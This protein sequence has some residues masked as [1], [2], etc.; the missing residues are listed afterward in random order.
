MGDETGRRH[1]KR[2][3]PKRRISPNDIGH[4]DGVAR[5]RTCFNVKLLGDQRSLPDVQ[6]VAGR[7][8]ETRNIGG[9]QAFCLARIEGSDV[10]ALDVASYLDELQE[11]SAV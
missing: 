8:I 9:N 6:Q 2:P 4:M 5:R 1:R 3:D 11:A 7:E 10:D